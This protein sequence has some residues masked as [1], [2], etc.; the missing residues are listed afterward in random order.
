MKE[1]GWRRVDLN[2]L[3]VFYAV[4]RYRKLTAA[5]AQLSMTQSAVSHA[6]ARLRH[7][8]S[9]ELFLR[10]GHG[11]EPTARALALAPQI[12]QIIRAAMETVSEQAA[13]DPATAETTIRIAM[14]DYE[15]A[16]I[17]P[18]LIEIV[19]SRAPGVTLI[20]SH[21]WRKSAIEMLQDNE[22]EIALCT[23]GK[24][25]KDIECQLIL[26]ED[27]AVIARQ[28][29]PLISVPLDA[30][31]YM[32]ADHLLVSFIGGTHGSVD[33]ALA[34][35]GGTR[36]VV[37]AMPG[38]IPA[39]L[40]VA[41]SNLIATLPRRVVQ[42]LA[43]RFDLQV[44]APPVAIRS[45]PIVMAWHRRHANSPIRKWLAAVLMELYPRQ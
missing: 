35:I 19:R 16:V 29:H 23:L 34:A 27:W 20:C 44:F 15:A 6:L 21:A 25:P 30:A 42:E 31:A 39:M 32:A 43:P 22:A 33:R 40:T 45:F 38:F 14:L 17:M 24:P 28:D 12:E 18:S 3:W 8:F 26:N 2:L 4:F 10:T 13:F 41:R 1:P 36:N 5:A 9:D 37:A 11:V 7:L